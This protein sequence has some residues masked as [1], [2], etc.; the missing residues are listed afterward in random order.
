MKKGT[1]KRPST[2]KEPIIRLVGNAEAL[3][4]DDEV[5]DIPHVPMA[6]DQILHG[7]FAECVD[8]PLRRADGELID[9]SKY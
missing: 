7:M 6:W 8:S 5:I 4:A 9:E 1:I 3:L 2:S